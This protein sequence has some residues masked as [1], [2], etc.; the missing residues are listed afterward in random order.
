MSGALTT[1]NRV[2]FH[3][4]NCVLTQIGA[5]HASRVLR[6]YRVY[7]DVLT[8][9]EAE[10]FGLKDLWNATALVRRYL[11]HTFSFVNRTVDFSSVLSLVCEDS[12]R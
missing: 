12:R 10:Y 7:L 9:Q 4:T 2:K 6:R 11:R 1:R 5:A 3:F 8:A